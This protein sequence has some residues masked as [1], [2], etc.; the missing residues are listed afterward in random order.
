[1]MEKQIREAL[2][3]LSY[4]FDAS[5]TALFTPLVSGK[6]LVIGSNDSADVFTDRNLK[7]YA[8]YDFIKITPS[9]I[10]FCHHFFK[11]AEGR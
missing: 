1:M 11:S 10:G 9:H 2:F 4:T 6:Y 5:V 7:K 3:N 8:P